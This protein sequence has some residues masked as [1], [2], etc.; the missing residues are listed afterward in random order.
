MNTLTVELLDKLIKS[1][2]RLPWIAE[3]LLN[4]V[5]TDKNYKNLSP[6]EYL[7]QG[8]EKVYNFEEMLG[9]SADRFYDELASAAAESIKISEY[10]D[11][12]T[13]IVIFDGVSLREIPIILNKSLESG[14]KVVEKNVAFAAL[15][16]KTLDFIGQKLVGKPVA[17]NTLPQRKELKEKNIRAYYFN[18]IIKTQQIESSNGEK[19]LIWSAFPDNTYQDF[20]AKFARHFS[21]IHNFFDSAWRNTVMQVHRKKRI[22]ITSDHGYIFFGAG[23]DST[24]HG[25][26][27]SLLDQDRAKFFSE[28]EK[29]PI[30]S[31]YPE[32]QIFHDRRLAMLRGRIKNH[33]KGPSS[34]KAYRHGGLSIMEMIIPW[35]VIEKKG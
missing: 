17:P 12:D 11:S 2:T 20:D 32:L 1:E 23:F 10:I 13:A 33:P 34:N 24:R 16:S 30:E 19:I 18:D 9:A 3:W 6:E 7:L 25:D 35:I 8:E 29:L 5:W 27:C 21:E 22:I 14:Y 4:E 15:P 31:D 28:D 26:A